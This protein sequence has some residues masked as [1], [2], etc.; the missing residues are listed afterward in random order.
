MELSA[1]SHESS[2]SQKMQFLN[3]DYLFSCGFNKSNE[4]QIKLYDLRNFTESVQNVPVDS[5]TGTMIPFYDPD[6]G[7]IYVPGRGEGNIKYFDFSNNTIK[8]ASEY[9]SSVPQKGIAAFPKRACNYNKCEVTRFAKLTIN[10]IEYVS[11]YVP[12]RNEGY[13]SSVYPD[14]L[15]GEAAL[16]YDN[17]MSG[18]NADPIRK[19]ITTLSDISPNTSGGFTFEKKNERC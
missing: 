11:F 5:Q 13:D 15:S 19:P 4:R 7:L 14:C 1:K 18:T 3:S 16:S 8:F 2:K 6:T 17:W 9:R 12:K 10:S